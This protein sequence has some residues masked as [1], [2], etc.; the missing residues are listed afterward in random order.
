MVVDARGELLGTNQLAHREPLIGV[1]GPERLVHQVDRGAAHDRARERHLLLIAARQLLRVERQQALEVHPR[2]DRVDAAADLGGAEAGGAQ[3]EPD[4]VADGQVRVERVELEDH[5]HVAP[6]RDGAGSRPGRPGGCVPPVGS[7]RP[8]IIRKV[9][10]LPQPE[11][12]SST[13]S[14]PSSTARSIPFTARVPSGIRLLDP[15]ERQEAHAHAA[16]PFP[17]WRDV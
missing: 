3:G 14:S 17:R 16:W 9:V 1:Q 5:P 13:T 7:S 8:A 11:G 6:R 4:V 15:F 10:V 12:P 2:G